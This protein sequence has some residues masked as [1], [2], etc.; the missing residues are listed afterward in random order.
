MTERIP[1][2]L[3]SSPAAATAPEPETERRHLRAL[4]AILRKDYLARADWSFALHDLA[5]M[6]SQA[7]E[8]HVGLVALYDEASKTWTAYTSSGTRL[9]DATISA[10]GS[11][12]ILEN[13]RLTGEPLLNVAGAPLP[14][15]SSSL[16]ALDVAAVLVVPLHW[17]D[18]SDPGAARTFGGCLYVHRTWAAPPFADCDVD[19]V[20]DITLI[21]QPLLNLLRRH[22][23]IEAE[24]E[25]SHR[26]VESLRAQ[27]GQSFRLGSYRTEDSEL[28]R[29]VIAP[30][31][32][33]AHADKVGL[34]I[35]G[36][37]G[38]GKSFLAEGY[39]CECARKAGP[40]V[41]LDCSQVVSAE[42]LA[43]ELFGYAADSGYANAPKK[44]RPGKAR[45]A[46]HG[47]LFI[48][49]V[50]AMPV[51]LQQQ[52]LRLIQ[53]GVFA[54]LGSGDEE[55]VDIQVIAATNESLAHLVR[56]GRFRE[57]LFWRLAEVAVTLPPLSRRVA[58]IPQLAQHFLILAA[59]RFARAAP[60]RL[61]PDAVHAL[62]NHPWDRTGNIRGLQN[63]INRSLLLSPPD[64]ALLLGSDLRFDDALVAAPLAVAVTPVGEATAVA[65]E[66][67]VPPSAPIRELL[68]RKLT[69]Y[70]GV[71]RAMALDGEVAG[72]LGYAG[73]ELPN[74]T[75]WLRLRQL[76]LLEAL[77]RA[78]VR[79]RKESGHADVELEIIVAAVR[80]HRS[81][82]KAAQAL[83]I[84][85][86]VLAWRLRKAGVAIRDLVREHQP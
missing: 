78:R 24:L 68:M 85:R 73:G 27:H 51:L 17:W 83:G 8:A 57:D 79:H 36:P 46:D 33:I 74:A 14:L 66:R 65:A 70:G 37:T 55:A 71:V 60:V 82:A 29:A 72:A 6:T 44:G 25:A 54:P 16:F 67:D 43:A 63:T 22:R 59:E 49:E 45:L 75:L 38:S 62:L 76:D 21:A 81:G 80:Q 61:A 34:L 58:D 84:T 56:A 10:E 39:H 41:T 35:L 69:E 30:L 28:A 42:T 18:V 64:R 3:R 5:R 23:A 20:R 9:A 40:F 15:G 7:L 11:R 50:G 1:D 52:L 2:W 53:T 48:D 31:R 4:R 19:L 13:V 32:R 77:E 12:A 47:T 26:E 86:D